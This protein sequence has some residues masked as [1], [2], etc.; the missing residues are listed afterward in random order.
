MLKISIILLAVAAMAACAQQATPVGSPVAS[1]P[2][3][4]GNCNDAGAQFALGRSVNAQ[5]EAEAQIRS[6]AKLVR[7]LRPG[8]ATTLEFN[9]Q[10]LNLAVDAAGHVVRAQCG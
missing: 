9:A 8:Q 1:H 10:R 7:V 4:G 3:A 6:G 2:A 5:L